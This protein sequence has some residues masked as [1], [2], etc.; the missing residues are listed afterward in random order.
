MKTVNL[1]RKSNGQLILA[2]RIDSNW[3]VEFTTSDANKMLDLLKLKGYE[4]I[5]VNEYSRSQTKTS[6]NNVTLK[7]IQNK[8]K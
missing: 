5:I 7:Q 6:C 1:S 4:N 8:L 3:T 2:D